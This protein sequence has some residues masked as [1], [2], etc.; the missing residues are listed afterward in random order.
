MLKFEQGFV[1]E[2]FIQDLKFFRIEYVLIIAGAL[3]MLSEVKLGTD[4]WMNDEL[5]HREKQ[6]SIS[7]QH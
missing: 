2:R 3:V 6:E 5:G 1:V 7:L 4:L